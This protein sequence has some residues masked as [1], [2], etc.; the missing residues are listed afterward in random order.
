[1]CKLI[2]IGQEKYC[3]AT[4]MLLLLLNPLSSFSITDDDE[5]QIQADYM[6]FDLETGSSTYRGNVS[7]IQG[8]IKLTGEN[9]IITRK[10]NEILDIK[11]DGKPAHY[12]QD[13]NTDNKVHAIS[14]HMK[15]TVQTHRLVLTVDA[16]LEQSSQ[17]VVSQ[18]IV[19]DTQ[20][21]IIIAG[22]D[23]GAE[24]PGQKGDRVNITL[25]PK[26]PSQENK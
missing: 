21:K 17:T 19:Y 24:Q 5:V 12:L 4:L 9:V 22:K 20:N 7:I 11:V 3:S 16:S 14:Q 25:T 18:R 13:E 1:M 23:G 6:K 15:Y 10:N 8:T 26:K 2:K